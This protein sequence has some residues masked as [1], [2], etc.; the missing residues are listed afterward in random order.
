MNKI[1]IIIV[2]VLVII[3][4]FFALNVLQEDVDQIEQDGSSENT[5]ENEE[6]NSVNVVEEVPQTTQ[7]SRNEIQVPSEEIEELEAQI[8]EELEELRSQS[9]EEWCISG[10]VYSTTFDGEEL[11]AQILQITTYEGIPVC[12]A[13]YI[14]EEET[15]IGTF[16][17]E[18][19][20]YI[21]EGITQMWVVT[22]LF[23]QTNIEY[24]EL[25]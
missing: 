8:Q 15:G 23:G 10:E 19:T 12:E 1:I 24:F 25:D 6:T 5:I 21:D 2:L 3:F 22:E 18:N 13:L 16:E 17:I 4:G 20:L 11:E 9:L 14:R 7:E